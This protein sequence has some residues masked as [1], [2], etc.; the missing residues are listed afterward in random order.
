MVTVS[1]TG[2][3]INP[4]L[5]NKVL[6]FLRPRRT[7]FLQIP[8]PAHCPAGGGDELPEVLD[9]SRVGGKTMHDE[10]KVG[11]EQGLL[12]THFVG[13]LKLPMKSIAGFEGPTSMSASST[14][15]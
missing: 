12:L 13:E 5:Q 2:T 9:A 3:L 8:L 14:K 11:G 7:L 10:S 15:A 6:P 1:S 4:H